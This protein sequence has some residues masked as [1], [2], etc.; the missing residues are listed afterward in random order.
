MVKKM[1][2]SLIFMF[3]LI[4]SNSFCQD[5]T[6]AHIRKDGCDK[7]LTGN[8]DRKQRFLVDYMIE[9]VLKYRTDTA[10]FSDRRELIPIRQTSYLI[11]TSVFDNERFQ[12]TVA[13]KKLRFSELG[14]VDL[15]KVEPVGSFSFK[16]YFIIHSVNNRETY[17]LSDSLDAVEL[18]TSICISDS[19][20]TYCLPDSVVKDLYF[21]NFQ[22]IMY[23]IHPVKMYEDLKHEG[24]N[25]LYIFGQYKFKETEGVDVR[26]YLTYMAKYIFY[27]GKFIKRIVVDGPVLA[28][29]NFYCDKFI[30]F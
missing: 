30:G 10:F 22:N 18:L 13:K 25:Y 1:Q 7:L 24:Y 16:P 15:E 14:K 8:E 26:D 28:D 2:F 23:P 20:G 29:Y 19:F 6:L 17:G 9:N 5:N 21:P 4:I 12:I 3:F 27:K 11:D